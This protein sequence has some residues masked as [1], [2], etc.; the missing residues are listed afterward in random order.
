[1]ST[2]AEI[3]R[4]LEKRWTL[5]QS[6][7]N[8]V[9]LEYMIKFKEIH[10]QHVALRSATVLGSVPVVRIECDITAI[11]R[12]P[13]EKV[14][15]R[16]DAFP[17][18]GIVI[19]NGRYVVVAAIPLVSPIRYDFILRVMGELASDAVALR[20]QAPSTSKTTTAPESR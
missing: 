9:T 15:Q 12:V 18:G 4:R 1:M 17:F 13:A 3:R 20:E 10:P 5:Q 16:N 14:L 8:L 6:F 11:D 2:F 19:R 7:P